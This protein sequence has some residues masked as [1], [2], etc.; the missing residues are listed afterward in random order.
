MLPEPCET[1][2][3]VKRIDLWGNVIDTFKTE[4]EANGWTPDQGRLL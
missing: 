4:G 3:T 2:A 1:V